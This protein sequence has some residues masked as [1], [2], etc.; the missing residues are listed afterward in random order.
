MTE[1][2]N[3]HI[4]QSFL[5]K[6]GKNLMVIPLATPSRVEDANIMYRTA[7]AYRCCVCKNW[8]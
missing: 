6:S 5:K 7:H 8:A 1:Q 3:A 4:W 2:E